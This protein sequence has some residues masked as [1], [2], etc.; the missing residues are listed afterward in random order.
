MARAVKMLGGDHE[1]QL[2]SILK[3]DG[4]TTESPTE[5]LNVMLDQHKP[6]A[7]GT[8]TEEG[9]QTSECLPE[10]EIDIILENYRMERVIKSFDPFK[11]PGPEWSLPRIAQ[12]G[13]G[14]T[15]ERGI[16]RD[17]RGLPKDRL[18]PE[19]LEKR[20]GDLSPKTREE[21]IPGRQSVQNDHPDIIPAKTS[22]KTSPVEIGGR[23]SYP[24]KPQ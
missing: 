22:G 17:L 23:P 9:P 21:I 15:P 24:I 10:E 14:H 3:R 6:K 16:Q 20:Q 18:C 11:S 12:R 8:K 4:S 19:I 1:A 13:M 7:E 5:T 2:S